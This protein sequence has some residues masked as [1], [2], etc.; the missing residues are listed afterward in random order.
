MPL[1]SLYFNL[2]GWP[3]FLALMIIL[4]LLLAN[5]LRLEAGQGYFTLRC[6]DI[7]GDHVLRAILAQS[8]VLPNGL[9]FSRTLLYSLL[10]MAGLIV[11]TF[12]GA[13]LATLLVHPPAAYKILS[14]DDLRRA[15]GKILIMHQELAFLNASIGVEV[16]EKNLDLFKITPSV[17]KMQRPLFRKSKEISFKE[18]IPVTMPM[19]R[20][21]IYR[22]VLNRY[23]SYTMASGLYDLWFRRSYHELIAVGKLNYSADLAEPPYHDLIWEDLYYVWIAYMGGTLFSLLVLPFEIVYFKWHR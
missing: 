6:G 4:A 2:K 12:Y 7:F 23:L 1:S 20:N 3:Y 8:F 13:N 14:Y 17:I 15:H 21:S 22:D 11:S 9:G 16:L 10:M 19:A 5:A 18:F